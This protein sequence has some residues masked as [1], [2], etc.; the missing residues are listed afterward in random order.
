MEVFAKYLAGIDNPE[1]CERTEEILAWVA[2][3]FPNLESQI[4]WNTP[5]FSDH[6]WQQYG[7]NH[8]NN[9]NDVFIIE[10]WT[11]RGYSLCRFFINYEIR[12]QGVVQ[13]VSE[14]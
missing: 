13:K 6:V 2:N 12:M 1:H 14:N 10:V 5:M 8:S 4:K 3:I 9:P 7:N 11:E